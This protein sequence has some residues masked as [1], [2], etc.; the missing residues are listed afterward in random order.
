LGHYN[1]PILGKAK[2]QCLQNYITK[3]LMTSKSNPRSSKISPYLVTTYFFHFTQ[4]TSPS[5]K[6]AIYYHKALPHS[7]SKSKILQLLILAFL[8]FVADA[9]HNKE[10]PFLHI[11]REKEI[12][13]CPWFERGFCREGALCRNS[14]VRRALCKN[15]MLGCCLAGKGTITIKIISSCKKIAPLKWP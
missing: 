7:T 15:H 14:H 5:R 9:C 6:K 2:R 1:C 4:P 11:E 13:D 3:S 8:L 12:R 10:C